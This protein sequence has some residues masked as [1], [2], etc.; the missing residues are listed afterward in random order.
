MG[1]RLIAGWEPA[2]DGYLANIAPDHFER[3]FLHRLPE[4]MSG[5]TFLSRYSGTADTVTTV[6]SDRNYKI[7]QP[8]AHPIY[9][10][11]RVQAFRQLLSSS[12]NEQDLVLLGDLM[13]QSH[14][15]YSACGLG[16]RG[17][18]LI[19]NLV[20]AEGPVHGLYGA[21]ITGGGS[22]GTVA[23]LGRSDAGPSV[24]RVVESY[25]NATGYRPYVFSGGNHRTLVVTT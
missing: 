11:H 16:S 5:A 13:Y 23:I 21:R 17:T 1:R 19:V 2:V 22:G 10:H 14:A 3:E 9:E 4:R 15:S 20:R 25:S 12:L 18:D 6:H 8:T 7:R 24:A